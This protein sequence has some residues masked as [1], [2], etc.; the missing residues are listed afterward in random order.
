ARPDPP[1]DRPARPQRAPEPRREVL[2]GD[3]AHPPLPA[4]VVGDGQRLAGLPD[5][6]GQA[7]APEHAQPGQVAVG[8]GADAQDHLAAVGVDQA[9]V[10]AGGADHLAGPGD[11]P[12]QQA[13]GGQVVAVDPGLQA[14]H[15]GAHGPGPSSR[16]RAPPN[17]SRAAW[18]WRANTT[19]V[20]GV[21]PAAWSRTAD[22]MAAAA[23]SSSTPPTPVPRAGRA[24]LVSPS[25]AA[26]G[27]GPTGAARAGRRGAMAA[28]CRIALTPRS[29][30]RPGPVR[31]ASPTG[32]GAWATA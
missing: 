17:R 10:A 9:D 3:L 20:T 32:H 11:D 1:D 6:A 21:G 23:A 15:L 26:R 13:A 18:S 14:V 25:A 8:A 7:L 4:A 30:R 28:A 19:V 5:P 2:D 16:S 12:L 31:T 27:R 24:T 22:P 29:A